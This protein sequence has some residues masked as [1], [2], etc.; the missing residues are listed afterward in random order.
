MIKEKEIKLPCYGIVVLCRTTRTDE[1]EDVAGQITHNGQIEGD[2]FS[3]ILSMILAH[4]LAD[5]DIESAAYIQGIES[6]V[7]NVSNRI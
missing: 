3:G 6:A 7:E 4:A 5:I 2:E 1:Y